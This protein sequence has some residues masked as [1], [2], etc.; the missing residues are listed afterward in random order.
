MKQKDS[1]EKR[2]LRVSFNKSGSGSMSS[3]VILPITWFK[4]M[5]V[6]EENRNIVATF[7]DGK[8]TI[9]KANNE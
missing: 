4:E 1:L 3:R 6:T 5:G 2:D 8:I 7:E 9:K